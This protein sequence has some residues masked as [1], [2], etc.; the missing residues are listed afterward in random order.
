MTFSRR[1]PLLSGMDLD[2]EAFYVRLFKASFIKTE[3][4]MNGFA[5]TLCLHRESGAECNGHLSKLLK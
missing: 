3:S 4:L 5:F 2:L 1:A